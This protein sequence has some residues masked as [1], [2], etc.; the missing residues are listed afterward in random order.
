MPVHRV[1]ELRIRV[2]GAVV[3]AVQVLFQVEVLLVKRDQGNVVPLGPVQHQAGHGLM[4]SLF[5]R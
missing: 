1:Y 5:S 3:P 4:A 2:G